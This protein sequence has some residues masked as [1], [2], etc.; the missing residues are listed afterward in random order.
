MPRALFGLLLAASALSPAAAIAQHHEGDGDGRRDRGGW[1]GGE[2]RGQSP[3]QAQPARQAPQVRQAPPQVQGGPSPQAFQRRGEGWQG[4]AN[5]D[6]V[7]LRRHAELTRIIDEIDAPLRAAQA[8]QAE[9]ERAAEQAAARAEY[10]EVQRMQEAVRP[11]GN[12]VLQGIAEGLSNFQRDSARISAIHN[13]S[14]ARIQAM[15]N[16]RRQMEANQARMQG[17]QQNAAEAVAVA[18]ASARQ[19]QAE[20]Q[21]RIQAAAIAEANRR[22]QAQAGPV[23][24]TAHREA[25]GMNAGSRADQNASVDMSSDGW[26]G[27]ANGTVSSVSEAAARALLQERIDKGLVQ[28]D[29]GPITC[30]AKV[31]DYYNCRVGVPPTA[32]ADAPRTPREEGATISK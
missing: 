16:D 30:G 4:R 3:R 8:A 32:A 19:A 22:E 24:L 1:H 14:M 29:G 20:A 9:A 27:G 11:R 26:A 31:G 13:E 28:T 10:E 21:R 25:S 18:Q 23:V 7:S 17:R 12:Y 6:E 5:G 2:S 15:E